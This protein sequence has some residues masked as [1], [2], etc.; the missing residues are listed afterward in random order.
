MVETSSSGFQPALEGSFSSP[1]VVITMATMMAKRSPQERTLG[2]FPTS[3]ISA[4]P[5]FG[6]SR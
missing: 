6:G 2:A 1:G 3:R 5:A 4:C